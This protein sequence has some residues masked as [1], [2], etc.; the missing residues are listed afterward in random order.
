KDEHARRESDPSTNAMNAPLAG[1]RVVELGHAV[2]A[3]FAAA[4][5]GDFGAD[6]IKVEHPD[7]GDSLRSMGPTLSGADFSGDSPGRADSTEDSLW[8][9]VAARNK[10]SVALN[11]KT[12]EGPEIL[13]RIIA[14]S[15]VVIENF[16]PG[17]L[18]K[19]GLGWSRLSETNPALIML[20]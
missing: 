9:R 20:S 10:R 2:A 16:R 6:V 3:P 4:L 15:D 5:L 1:M 18:D 14:S 17:V 12:D 7:G 19:Y 11:L 8:W 13:H